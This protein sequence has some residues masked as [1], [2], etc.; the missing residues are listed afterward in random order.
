MTAGQATAAGSDQG[1]SS[2]GVDKPTTGEP[3]HGEST[4]YAG[5]I[6]RAQDTCSKQS[7]R[8]GISC[9]YDC[10][11]VTFWGNA[12]FGRKT[13]PYCLAALMLNL[14]FGSRDVLYIHGHLLLAG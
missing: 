8:F 4:V 10:N 14:L 11:N 2:D 3:G 9:N 13:C 5:D 7:Y 6:A 1:R 12:C